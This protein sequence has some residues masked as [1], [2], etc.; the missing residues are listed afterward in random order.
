MAGPASAQVIAQSYG[1][2]ATRIGKVGHWQLSKIENSCVL[3]D[4]TISGT[5][6]YLLKAP[7]RP[8]VVMGLMNSGWSSIKEGGQYPVSMTLGTETQTFNAEGTRIAG[9]PGIRY[10]IKAETLW[11][12]ARSAFALTMNGTV[13]MNA[14]FYK[15][16][17]AFLFLSRCADGNG[18]GD[19]FAK[20]K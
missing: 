8:Y 18:A 4:H 13:L 1:Q 2:K 9:L 15:E 11:A 6:V 16:E 19:P 20:Q 14:G 12:S 7:G 5:H 10:G 3:E 17:E